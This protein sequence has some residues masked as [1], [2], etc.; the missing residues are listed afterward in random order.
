VEN[1][2]RNR[3]LRLFPHLSFRFEP[4]EVVIPHEI[5]KPFFL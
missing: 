2:F 1:A 3:F 5:N 4:A